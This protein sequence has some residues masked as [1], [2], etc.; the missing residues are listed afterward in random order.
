MEVRMFFHKSLNEYPSRSSQKLSGQKDSP[1]AIQIYKFLLFTEKTMEPRI[2]AL[3]HYI[4][5]NPL[6]SKDAPKIEL[7]DE[8]RET[9]T[10]IIK[11]ANLSAIMGINKEF[12]PRI[13]NVEKKQHVVRRLKDL[14]I[15]CMDRIIVPD[16]LP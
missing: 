8:M 3:S 9:Y 16:I 12:L 13:K 7:T 14:V 2:K 15:Q 1:Y 10:Q 4:E 5:T 11:E 6:F